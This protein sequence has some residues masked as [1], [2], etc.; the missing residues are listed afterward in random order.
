MPSCGSSAARQHYATQM[1]WK[2]PPLKA[3][4][5]VRH[6]F[7]LPTLVCYHSDAHSILS[8]ADICGQLL[9]AELGTLA[10]A[11]PSL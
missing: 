9:K 2:V 11:H 3:Y 8:R 10:K 7:P 4:R 1:R 6:A 5:Q